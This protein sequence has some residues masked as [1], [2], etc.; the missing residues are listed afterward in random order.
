MTFRASL[1]LEKVLFY[2]IFICILAASTTCGSSWAR[3]GIQATAVTYGLAVAWQGWIF[4]PLGHSGNSKVFF[5]FFKISISFII[6]FH[7]LGDILRAKRNWLEIQ[8]RELGKFSET[9]MRVVRE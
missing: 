1:S 6:F 9:R 3:S 5:F 2:F 8:Y 4:N 7:K